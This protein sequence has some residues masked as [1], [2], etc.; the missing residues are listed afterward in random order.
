[1]KV[2][3]QQLLDPDKP[4]WP[5]YIEQKTKELARKDWRGMPIEDRQLYMMMFM[6]A[7]DASADDD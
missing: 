1:M 4:V 5:D 2:N 7:K 3:I 6:G